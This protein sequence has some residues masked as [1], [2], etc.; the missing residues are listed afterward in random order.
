[1]KKKGLLV[2]VIFIVMA[3]VFAGCQISEDYTSESVTDN[4]YTTT[5]SD[6]KTGEI[7]D[8]V[9]EAGGTD[10]LSSEGSSTQ[11]K[12][13]YYA[14]IDMVCDNPSEAEEA[15][16]E[17]LNSVGGYVSSSQ[18]YRDEDDNSFSSVYLQLRVPADKLDDIKDFI[19]ELGEVTYSDTSS[20]DVSEYYYDTEARLEYQKTE[21]AQLEQLMEEASTIEEVL[22]VRDQLTQVQEQIEVYQSQIDNWDSLVSYSTL[23]VSV[24]RTASAEPPISLMSFDELIRGISNGFINS[25]IFVVNMLGYLLILLV[26]LLIPGIFVAAIVLFIVWLVKRNKKK[27]KTDNRKKEKIKISEKSEIKEEEKAEDK[28]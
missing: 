26:S 23:S 18:M 3:L 24:T 5:D 9:S 28:K 12:I 6:E 11:D 10:N 4:G 15:I 14:N 13:I 1:M 21:A 2:L 8:E 16:T 25:G 19:G 20:E 27:K 22:L 17:E 7:S